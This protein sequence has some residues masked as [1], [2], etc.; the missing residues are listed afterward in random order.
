MPE[1]WI[2]IS[3]TTTAEAAD[4]LASRLIELGS[5]GAVFDDAPEIAADAC[6]VT[7]YYPQSVEISALLAQIQA[8]LD[9]LQRLGIATAPGEVHSRELSD[10]DWATAWKQYFKPLRIGRRFVVKPS[11]ESYEP[12]PDDL[13]IEIDPGMAFGTGLHASTRLAL[14]LLEEMEISGKQ[15]L[16]VGVGS[17]ILSIAAAR[18]E[19]RYVLGMDIDAEAVAIARDNV[20]RNFGPGQTRIALQAGSL[21]TLTITG[22]FDCILMNIRPEVIRSLSRRAGELFAP[23]GRLILSG[24]LVEEGGQLVRELAAQEALVVERQLREEGW[25]VY[26]LRRA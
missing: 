18:L 2:E 22:G 1:T 12:G 15:V 16:D 8:Q 19:A 10:T 21:D 26:R 24:I 5:Q 20:E 13:L 17:G 14:R 7:G 6:R 25:I 23:E 3:V 9:D 4:I 11:W